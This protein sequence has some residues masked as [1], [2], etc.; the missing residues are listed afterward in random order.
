MEGKKMGELTL[1]VKLKGVDE[2]QERLAKAADYIDAAREILDSLGDVVEIGADL[3][4][5]DTTSRSGDS[6][7]GDRE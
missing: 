1:G 6:S 2:L 5:S 4:A 7:S 3:I